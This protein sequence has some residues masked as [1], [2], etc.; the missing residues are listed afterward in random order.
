M[1]KAVRATREQLIK[2]GVLKPIGPLTVPVSETT[3]KRVLSKVNAI[4]ARR[5]LVNVGVKK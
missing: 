3:V 1:E 2:S 5:A 4:I